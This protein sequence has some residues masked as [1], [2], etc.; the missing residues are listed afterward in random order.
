MCS[1]PL[2][3][4]LP[5]YLIL[6]SIALT[7]G[8]ASLPADASDSANSQWVHPGPDGKLVYKTVPLGDRI[9]DFSYAGYM[10]GG[11]ALPTV[12]VKKTI[13]PSGQNNDADTIQS[14]IN[15]VAK[16]P[17]VNGFRGAV[18]LAP[19][20]YA[21]SH[22][23]RIPTS[24]IVLR[25]S[26]S[27]APARNAHEGSSAPASSNQVST[28]RLVGNPHLAIA[29]S[30]SMRGNLGPDDEAE[31]IQSNDDNTAQKPSF[32]AA[33]T[34]VADA[35]V[36]S[37]AKSFTVVNAKGFAVGD[38]IEI[39]HPVTESWVKFMQMD[40]MVRDGKAQTWIRVGN[41]ITALRNITGVSGNRIV[42]DVPLSDSFDAKYLSPPGAAVVKV[43][44]AIT[45][46]QSGIEDLHIEC[47]AQ[48]INHAQKH[49]QALRIK[50]QDCWARNVVCDETMN[51]VSISGRRITLL[52]VSVNR[53]A[54]HQGSSR[55]AEFAPNASQTLLDRCSV[56]AD[57]VWFSAT[58]GG[59]SGPIVLL[60]CTFRGKSEAESHQRWSTGILYDNCYVPEGG[61]TLRNRGSMG[62]GHGWTMGWGVIWNCAAKDYI[63]QNPP[64]AVNWLI[65]SVGRDM[66]APRPFGSGPNLAEGIIDS[67]NK[68]VSP[69]SL[70]LAQLAERLGAKAVKN[71]GY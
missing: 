21:C 55:P 34:V 3:E 64:G 54:K 62:S 10:G 42:V 16:L 43:H 7:F 53:R 40:D 57:N 41:N 60:N 5:I 17:I 63:V 32:K 51:S 44:P 48:A 61:I 70:Y 71:I 12:A 45:I 19:G 58:G 1:K 27:G 56:T 31:A 25:G 35:Y 20:T 36:P 13:S 18:L 15:E 8:A 38:T 46:S 22:I 14:A 47:P 30:T 59:V 2:D 66:L 69:H 67:F 4:R 9:M 6:A 39:E 24:G 37:G 65:G 49:F 52:Q 68:P 28:I 33:A 23:I 11:V 29:L 26:G 50:G